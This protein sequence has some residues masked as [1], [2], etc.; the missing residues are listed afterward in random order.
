[1]SIW[2]NIDIKDGIVDY[3]T[4]SWI[5][6]NFEVTEDTV[7]DLSQDLLQ[8]KF[9]EQNMIL[10]V[11]WYPDLDVNGV[12]RIILVK[13]SVW[14]YPVFSTESRSIQDLKNNISG[15]IFNKIYNKN[16][17]LEK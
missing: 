2:W 14:D 16:N 5:N 4:I 8:I 7:F 6:N 10:D 17:K 9:N 3:D 15:I 12:F 11:G 13:N 1:M